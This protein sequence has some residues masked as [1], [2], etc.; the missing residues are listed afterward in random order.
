MNTY[1][2][3]APN[4]RTHMSAT[5]FGTAAIALAIGGLAQPAISHAAWDIEKYDKCL[6]EG[7]S[8]DIGCCIDSGGE[9]TDWP[10]LKCVAP[11]TAQAPPENREGTGQLPGTGTNQQSEPAQQT[12]GQLNQTPGTFTQGQPAPQSPAIPIHPWFG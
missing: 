2:L 12:P 11:L 8:S 4:R 7:K 1:Q 9:L 6:Q 3:R 10:E 5:M